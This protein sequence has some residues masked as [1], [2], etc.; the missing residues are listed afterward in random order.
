M[1]T[2]R[3]FTL[4]FAVA[5]LLPAPAS[6]QQPFPNSIAIPGTDV[7]FRLGGYV[8]IDFI[9]DLDAIGDA[10]EFATKTIP[11]GGPEA[12]LGPRTTIHAR[13]TRVN[14][15]VRAAD[16]LKVF[17]EGD[18]FGSG[19]GF[20][21]RHAYG[22]FD[23]LLGGQTWSTFQ[24]IAARPLTLDFEGPDGEVFV[25]QAMLRWTQPLSATTHWAL[26]LENPTPQLAVPDDLEGVVQASM[27]DLATNL[28]FTS[29]SGHVQL[30]GLLRQIRFD[31]QGASDDVST[32]GWGVNAAFR[33]RA[34]GQDELMGQVVYGEGIGRYVESFGGQDVDAVFDAD[35]DL[36]TIALYAVT[37]GYI[38]HWRSG[39]KSG[40][41][42]SM[43]DLEPEA[44]Q[45]AGSIEQTR[46]VRVNLIATPMPKVDIGGEVLY[47]RRR[48]VSGAAGEAWRLQFAVT[49]HIN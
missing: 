4:A 47:G 12:D 31:G 1:R 49:Y 24:D 20:R 27:P 48:D 7:A 15:E 32:M 19:N 9:Q 22:Q 44:P 43:A 14:L 23:R 35:D 18:F 46:D 29:P 42:F 36:Q 10:F 33:V 41:A 25:R 8:K 26:A 17:V 28:R 2:L 11:T 5:A 16:R 13:E 3:N 34:L 6:T 39:L 45:P 40:L 37:L 21:L 38:H 30:S